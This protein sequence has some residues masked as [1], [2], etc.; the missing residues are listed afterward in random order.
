MLPFCDCAPA[1]CRSCPWHWPRCRQRLRQA[2][3]ESG[4]GHLRRRRSPERAHRAA[5]RDCC[6]PLAT[7]IDGDK[8]HTTTHTR[9][10][11][12]KLSSGR[13]GAEFGR[14]CNADGPKT[15]PKLPGPWARAVW[16]RFF[17]RPQY[18]YGQNRPQT[19]PR[20]I[21]GVISEVGVVLWP[22]MGKGI[23]MAA[24]WFGTQF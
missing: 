23:R 22:L 15:G 18:T 24:L 17:I 7:T 12:H 5:S 19:G 4:P 16:G 6:R 11:T 14:K 21:S 2:P 10:M 13:F 1:F 9:E 3:L 8:R 20:M